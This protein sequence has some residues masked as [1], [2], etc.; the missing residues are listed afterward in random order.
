MDFLTVRVVPHT[1]QRYETVGDWIPGDPENGRPHEIIVSQTGDED[2]NIVCALHELIEFWLCRKHG[3]EETKVSEFDKA[4]DGEDPG[5]DEDAPYHD[6]HMAA[7]GI[8]LSFLT[9]IGKPIKEY[10]HS[11]DYENLIA[12][13]PPESITDSSEAREQRAEASGSS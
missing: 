3:V 8:E 13:C 9:M 5:A 2:A 10:D 1:E 4:F 12:H 6:E 7:T 11:W